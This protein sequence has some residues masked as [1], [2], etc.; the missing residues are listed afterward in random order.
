VAAG[1][2][3][4]NVMSVQVTLWFVNPLY[5]A[6]APCQAGQTS[7]TSQTIQMTRTIALMNK[8]GVNT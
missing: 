2:Y 5:C 8:T 6:A 7:Q 1:S 3:W 4:P